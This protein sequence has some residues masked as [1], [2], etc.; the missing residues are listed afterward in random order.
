M[1]RILSFQGVG[2]KAALKR[3]VAVL[4]DVS[5][6]L[7]DHSMAREFRRISHQTSAARQVE[8]LFWDV[9]LSPPP[10]DVRPLR[11]FRNVTETKCQDNY[12]VHDATTVYTTAVVYV[13]LCL[14]CQA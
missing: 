11:V 6:H 1:V 4:T 10:D 14:P 3:S 5:A 13:R 7:V 12:G 2:A 8:T 9:M